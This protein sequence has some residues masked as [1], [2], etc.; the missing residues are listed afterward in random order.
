MA[1]VGIRINLLKERKRRLK[2]QRAQYAKIQ[3]LALVVLSVY[4]VILFGVIM[5][6][7]YASRQ[8][9]KLEAAITQETQTIDSL[10][11]LER[12]YLTV[13]RKIEKVEALVSGKGEERLLFEKVY[14]GLP[15]GVVLTS[16]EYVRDTGVLTVN[17]S[18][19]QIFTLQ[20]FIDWIEQQLAVELLTEVTINSLGRS[21][22]ANYAFTADFVATTNRLVTVLGEDQ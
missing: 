14:R 5:V 19:S 22:S 20:S 7:L 2:K 11:N 15:E 12:D 4:G 3:S 10:V 1:N 16:V 8:V 17:G 6:N 18:A 21:Q 13:V 9:D